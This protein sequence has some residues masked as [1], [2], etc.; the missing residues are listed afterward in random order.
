MHCQQAELKEIVDAPVEQ[1]AELITSALCRLGWQMKPGNERL[2]YVSAADKRTDH[3]GRDVW[4][5]DYQA[6][7]KWRENA[8]GIELNVNVAEKANQWTQEE[9]AKRC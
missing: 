7:V 2:R 4:R 8:N 5:F 9:C 3:I 1:A 6:L